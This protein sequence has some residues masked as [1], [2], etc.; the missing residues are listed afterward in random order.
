MAKFNKYDS[1]ELMTR[2][3]II[4]QWTVHVGFDVKSAVR[5]PPKAVE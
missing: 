2:N 5:I 1:Y 3:E 4:I